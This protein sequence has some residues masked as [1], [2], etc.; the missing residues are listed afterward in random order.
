[1]RLITHNLI[2][3][4]T[5]KCVGGYPLRISLS[6]ED[7]ACKTEPQV[8]NPQFIRKIIKRMD[9]PV[10]VEAAKSIGLQLPSTYSEE[11]LEDEKFI[12]HIHHCILEFHVLEATMQCPK[13]DRVYKV[14]KG[15]PNMLHVESVD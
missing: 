6:I 2:M 1:M 10:L 12:A 13:C 7:N 8:L 3:C 15:I 14:S 11:D 9:Y 4:N 5:D